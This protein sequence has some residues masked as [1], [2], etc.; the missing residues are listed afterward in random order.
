ML[1]FQQI[2]LRKFL[3][4]FSLLFLALGLLFYFWIKDFYLG[5]TRDALISNL[6]ILSLDIKHT[7]DYD[8]LAQDIKKTLDIRLTIISADGEVLAESHDDKKKMENHKYREEII[9]TNKKLFATKIRHSHTLNVDLLYVATKVTFENSTV[10]IRLAKELT[11]IDKHIFM[12]GAEITG[13]LLLFFTAVFIIT[14]RISKEINYEVQKIGHFVKSLT[15]KEKSTYVTSNFSIEFQNITTL[16]TKV[17]QILVKKEKQK[18][19]FTNKLQLSNRQKDDI[20]SAISHEFKNPI[21][22]INGYS[23]TLMDDININ[24]NIRQ[25]FLT[26]IYKNGIKLSELIDTLRLSSK[27]D[28]GKQELQFKN[29]NINE[30]VKDTV[31]SLSLNYPKRDVIIETTESVTIKGD[32]SLLGVVITNLLENAF[33]YSEDEVHIRFHQKSLSVIDSGIGISKKDLENITNKFYRVNENSWNNSLG[34]GL[35]IVNNILNLHK[36]TLKI[37]SKEKEGSTFKIE[38]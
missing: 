37:E 17:A 38:F 8:L 16:L 34:L 13:L 36:F 12:L 27:L 20:I 11:S 19:K 35:F 32:A 21:A 29:I 5:Q 2:L 1:S 14:Y 15:K 26:K 24:P 6:K 23:Q 33:K 9:A 22:V 28:S 30:L 7:K 31:E 3:L 10:Y 4:G 18:S 25:K